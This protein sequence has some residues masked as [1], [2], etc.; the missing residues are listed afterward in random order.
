MRP[1]AG[2]AL[3]ALALGSCAKPEPAPPPMPAVLVQTVRYDADASAAVFAGEIRARHET[4]LAFRIG[5]KMVARE[6]DAGASVRKGQVLARLD[7]ADVELA[8]Q[9][10][11]A[12]FAAARTE[13]RFAEAELE[14]SRALLARRFISQTA[15]DAKQSAYDAARARLDQARSQANVAANQS[16]YAALRADQDGVITAAPAERGQVVQ[17]GQPVLRL[18]LPQDKEA[19]ITV[20]EARLGELRAARRISVRLWAAPERTYAAKVREIAPS[21]DPATRSFQV[22]LALPDAD[23]AVRLGMT[24]DVLL[25]GEGG[26]TAR[27]PLAALGSREGRP[28]LWVV[29]DKG[30]VAPRP[31]DVAAYRHESALIRGGVAEGERVVVAGVHKLSAGQQVTPQPAPPALDRPR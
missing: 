10:A 8:A 13:L 3:C 24:A 14:R 4:D 11:Q 5:G 31:A 17:A 26:P 7:P 12:Q 15:F 29:D 18:A 16:T 9:G 25:A 28:V 20:P 22:K 27:L 6:V 1:G 30:V 2:L 23:A 19:V 21:A